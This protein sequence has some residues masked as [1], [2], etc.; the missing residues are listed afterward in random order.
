MTY[1]TFLSTIHPDDRE[2]VDKKWKAALAGEKY[3]IEHRIVVG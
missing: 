1:E 3:D 2:Y